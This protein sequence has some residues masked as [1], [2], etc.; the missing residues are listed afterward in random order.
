MKFDELKISNFRGIDHA[1]LK[2]VKQLNLI[3][4]KNNSGKTSILEALFV[5]SGM[6]NPQ[7]LLIINSQRNFQLSDD[8]NFKYLFNNLKISEVIELEGKVSGIKRY[9]K[10]TPYK[11]A[12]IIISS[13]KDDLS[14]NQ[15]IFSPFAPSLQS[16]PVQLENKVKEIDGLKISFKNDD[17]SKEDLYISLKNE[18]M[19]FSNSYKEA[20][21]VRYL[22]SRFLLMNGVIDLS[23]IVKKKQTKELVDILKQIEPKLSD[24]R[25]M[26]DNAIYF[27][28]GTDELLPIN[29]MG[30]GIIRT[31][32]V[33]SSMYDM[34]GGVLLLDEI[35]NGLHYSSVKVFWKAVL[36]LAKKLDVQIIATT[37]SYEALGALVDVKED[38]EDMKEDITPEISLYRVEKDE[39]KTRITHYNNGDFIFDINKN[40]EVR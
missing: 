29:I 38:L 12:Q 5:L 31:L 6:S 7:L 25:I 11:D 17:S 18:R 8:D 30:D 39:D 37:H 40:Y 13:K 9:L 15:G 23:S 14:F 24:I 36:L 35:E 27:D 10:I 33:L 2:D 26:K 22:S 28:I 19:S 34:S 20:L 1:E 16:G 3:V 21:K 4:G 32:S